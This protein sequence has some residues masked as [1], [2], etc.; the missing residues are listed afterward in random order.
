M[1]K[2]K[3]KKKKKKKEKKRKKKNKPCATLVLCSRFLKDGF[4]VWVQLSEILW[5]HGS[6]TNFEEEE[7]E[8]WNCINGKETKIKPNIGWESLQ[9]PAWQWSLQGICTQGMP[10]FQDTDTV[11]YLLYL[12][13]F[14]RS[15]HWHCQNLFSCWPAKGPNWSQQYIL[16][17]RNRWVSPLHS[18]IWYGFY[19][20]VRTAFCAI[21][22]VA[23]GHAAPLQA[24]AGAMRVTPPRANRATAIPPHHR[25]TGRPPQ[26]GRVA[27]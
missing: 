14:G 6:N 3:A 26:T 8:F 5:L 7:S 23:E 17:S 9:F 4:H 25:I 13:R 15:H 10:T 24:G 16:A 20:A 19:L 21:A 18:L 12:I 27:S 2:Q 22:T 11:F 1:K